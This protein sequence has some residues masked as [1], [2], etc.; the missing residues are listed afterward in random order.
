MTE[1]GSLVVR[2]AGRVEDV[3]EPPPTLCVS[4]VRQRRIWNALTSGIAIMSDASIRSKP[5][6]DQP[7]KPCRPR[8]RR[9]PPARSRTT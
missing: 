9:A 7:S 8:T 5:V 6:I 4:P 2:L 1:R 3:A